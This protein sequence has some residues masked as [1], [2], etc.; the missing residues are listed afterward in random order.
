MD[1]REKLVELLERAHLRVLLMTL[2]AYP[3]RENLPTTLSPTA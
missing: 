3:M 1:V 2:I